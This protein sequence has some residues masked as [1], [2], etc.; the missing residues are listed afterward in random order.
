MT[1]YVGE[2][3]REFGRR[4]SYNNKISLELIVDE[5]EFT[6]NQQIKIYIRLIINLNIFGMKTQLKTNRHHIPV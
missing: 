4:V 2:L 3:N 5:L 6:P 1:W